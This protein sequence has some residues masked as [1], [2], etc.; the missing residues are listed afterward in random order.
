MHAP[1]RSRREVLAGVLAA[2]AAGLLAA[3]GGRGSGAGRSGTPAAVEGAGDPSLARGLTGAITVSY[4][5]ELGKKP[6]YVEQAA[7][8]V[9]QANPGARV[10]IDHQ[11][12]SAGDY[13]RALLE[14]LRTDDAPDVIHV[15]GDRIGE[16]ADAGFITPLDD[17]LA[18]WPDWRYYPPW[19]RSAVT[20][21]G[22]VWAVPYGLDVRFLYFR[23]DVFAQAGLGAAWQP[24]TVEDLLTAA[25]TVRARVP[26]VIPYALYAGPANDTG[27]ASHGFLPL[28]Y[29]YGGDLQTPA[30]KW[31]GD[32]PAIRKV[33]AF[34]E[35]AFVR[36]RL[37]PAEVLT[38]TRPWVAMRE[39]LGT[40]RL[41]LLFDG[42]WVYGGWAGQ[43]P[44]GTEKNIG[45]LLFPTER[46]GPSFTI[47]GAGT[48]WFI[49]A[50]GAH[51]A[52]AW[53]FIKAWNTKDTVARLNVEDP[54]PVARADA[55]RVP[56]VRAEQFLVYS[57]NALE[58]ARFLPVDANYGRV[59]GAIQSATGRVAVGEAGPEEAARLYTEELRRAVG[60][61]NVVVQT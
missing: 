48:C 46:D 35:R 10:F 36:E 45:Y 23:R 44:A 28:L 50:A 6:P 21:R 32:S 11:R 13:Y 60:D 27:T 19:V 59:L 7:A 42:G 40:G 4:P 2:G 47:G 33:F 52:L 17:Y 55:V 14:R 49:T 41:A 58:R 38:G 51:K 9:E 16:L 8:L 5:D 57:T 29:A 12:L 1:R 61:D 15:G 53:E 39:R 31:I 54:H 22:Q 20:Y 25:A 43:D 3:C 26:H 18:T 34:Y 30:G 56:E 24:R 37:V